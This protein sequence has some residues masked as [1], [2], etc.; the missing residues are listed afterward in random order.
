MIYFLSWKDSRESG[1]FRTLKCQRPQI[2]YGPYP[3]LKVK[4]KKEKSASHHGY[5]TT[6][7][8]QNVASKSAV[9]RKIGPLSIEWSDFTHTSL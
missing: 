2:P 4:V 8:R 6:A 3:K 9:D 7:P 1:R 5:R